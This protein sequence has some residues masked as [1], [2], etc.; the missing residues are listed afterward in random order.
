LV[1]SALLY[2]CTSVAR[3]PR[4]FPPLWVHFKRNAAAGSRRSRAKD[5][6]K[7]GGQAIPVAP[8]VPAT[9]RGRICILHRFFGR[10]RA[11]SE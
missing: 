1:E 5:L 11:P 9:N 6:S 10:V 2:P 7:M 8:T 4:H 3:S